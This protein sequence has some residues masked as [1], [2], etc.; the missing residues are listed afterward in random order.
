MC[1]NELLKWVNKKINNCTEE[2]CKATKASDNEKIDKM[3]AEMVIWLEVRQQVEKLV[4][5]TPCIA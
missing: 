5:L 3:G 1:K 4:E 2:Y